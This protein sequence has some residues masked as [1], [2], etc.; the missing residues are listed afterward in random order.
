M[1]TVIIYGAGAIGRAIASAFQAQGA[2]VFLTSRTPSPGVEV[3]DALD[4]AAVEAHL[5]TVVERTGGLDVSI[6]VIGLPNALILGVPLTELALDRFESPLMAYVRA[7]FLT[8]RL[9]A[10][11][12]VPRKTGVL[13]TVTALHSRVG[14]PLVGGYG[15]A[16]A[17]KEALTRQLSAELSPHGLRVV[18]LRP[19]AMPETPTIREAFE[20][21]AAASGL[22][23]EQWQA[24]LA[25]RTHPRRLMALK[26]L[27]DAALF[28]ASDAAR[29]LTGTT[30]N[31]TLGSVDD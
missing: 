28:A 21:R 14:L 23:W 2:R 9:A 19:Q 24:S 11:F 30:L 3:V 26:E 29:G 7:Y 27:T 22:S 4:E 12:M 16:M 20:P 15:V 18:G 10:R 13:M 1:K 5:R 17:A 6:N 8:A 25:S 31:L